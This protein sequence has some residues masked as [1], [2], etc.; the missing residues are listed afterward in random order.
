MT[1]AYPTVAKYS[2]I[3]MHAIRVHLERKA[4]YSQGEFNALATLA[5]LRQWGDSSYWDEDFIIQHVPAGELRD[6]LLRAHAAIDR[7]SA[8]V[9]AAEEELDAIPA[10]ASEED[11]YL[12]NLLAVIHRDGGH[13][14]GKHGLS[15]SVDRAME[16]VVNWLALEDQMNEGAGHADG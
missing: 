1:T 5:G 2:H 11:A 8:E 16:K 4:D 6:A 15:E 10:T 14:T 12:L 7:F 13:F 9:D 3:A